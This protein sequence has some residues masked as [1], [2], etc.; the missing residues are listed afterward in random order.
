ME[1][2][3]VALVFIALI[4]FAAF[5]QYLR[6]HRRIMV[7]R[8]R[9]AA[10]EKGIELPPLDQEVRRSSVNVSRILLFAGLIWMSVGIGAYVVLSA[11]LAHPSPMT[12]EIPEGIQW[13]GIAPVGIGLSHL[14]GY[15]LG[16]KN[17]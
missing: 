3:S 2:F 12:A 5:Q 7:H 9:L 8:E 15:A 11:L 13:I 10:V 17:A 1:N 6:H 14:I 4:G 16:R